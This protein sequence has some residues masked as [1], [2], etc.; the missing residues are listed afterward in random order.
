M[1]RSSVAKTP[2]LTTLPPMPICGGELVL[3]CIQGT[4]G[5]G[6]PATHMRFTKDG[7]DMPPSNWLQV[8]IPPN[9]TT[10]ITNR[11]DERHHGEYRCEAAI[12][13][14]GDGK[15]TS[16]ESVTVEGCTGI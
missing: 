1:F 3:I 15:S 4:T 7:N 11:L 8:N 13:D 5:N 10:R 6:V 9:V 14:N 16:L 12:N 2:I